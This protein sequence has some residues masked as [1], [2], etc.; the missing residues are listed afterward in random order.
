M[1]RK[2]LMNKVQILGIDISKVTYIEAIENIARYIEE[3][4]PVQIVT[5]NAEIVFTASREQKLKDIVNNSAMVTAD[6]IGVVHAAKIKGEPVPCKV[7]GVELTEKLLA[8][9]GQKNWK[10][11]FLGGA[12]G[13]PEKAKSNLLQKYP[14][15]QIVGTRNGYFTP[16][17]EDEIIKDIIAKKPDILFVALGF[18]KQ[19][20]WIARNKD[21]INVPVS[22]GVGGS[23][24]IFSGNKKRAPQL[25]QKLGIEFFYRFLQEPRRFR[26]YFALP[27]FIFAFFLHDVFKVSQKRVK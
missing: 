20:L 11:Y 12:P 17:E 2:P 18:P 5:A 13:V 24:D 10:F 7:A 25:V 19:E 26:R 8:L 16:D 21:K 4:K 23:L 27:K 22:I 1:Q 15:V 14:D 3:K 6:G 9:S